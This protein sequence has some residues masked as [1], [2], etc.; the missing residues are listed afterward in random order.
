MT[1]RELLFYRGMVNKPRTFSLT[2]KM[3]KERYY[4]QL[5]NRDL[6]FKSLKRKNK[7]LGM[8]KV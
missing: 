8:L 5:I 2:L 6:I 7:K 4:D 1:S 3:S